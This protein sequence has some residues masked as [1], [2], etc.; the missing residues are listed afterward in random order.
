ME[1][2]TKFGV[3]ADVTL[4][5]FLA[6]C[7]RDCQGVID[8][9][10]NFATGSTFLAVLRVPGDGIHLLYLFPDLRQDRIAHCDVGYA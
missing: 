6:L 1:L 8:V 3:F 2:G 10:S 4:M 7:V 5:K 9:R